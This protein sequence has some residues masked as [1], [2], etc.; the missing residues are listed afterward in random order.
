MDCY[1]IMKVNSGK[2]VVSMV[3]M[4]LSLVE[5]EIGRVLLVGLLLD[6]CKMVMMILWLRIVRIGM[7][8]LMGKDRMVV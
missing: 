1:F 8:I 6:I 2:L 7:M 5:S 3:R 4:V